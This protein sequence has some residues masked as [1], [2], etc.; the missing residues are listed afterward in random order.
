VSGTS[1]EPVVRRKVIVSGRVQGVWFRETCR[2]EAVARAVSGYVR[3]LE[4]GT[5]EAVFEGSR[6]A[7]E[8]MVAWCRLGPTN[9]RVVSVVSSEQHPIEERAFHVY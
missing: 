3:N 5:V 2:T 4:D 6:G 7:V 8:E 1:D 9:A